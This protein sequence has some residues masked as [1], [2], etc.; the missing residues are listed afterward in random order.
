MKSGIE[1]RL[2]AAVG[3]VFARVERD[4]VR[5]ELRKVRSDPEANKLTRLMGPKG[6][7][8]RYADGG[9]DHTGRT[10]RFCWSCWKNAAGYFLAW[11]E[12]RGENQGE[13]VGWTAHRTRKAARAWSTRWRDEWKAEQRRTSA[14]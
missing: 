11:K 9:R 13:R 8:Y 14:S 12:V 1:R 4:W 2:E 10:V 7:T 3:D 6:N 5:D